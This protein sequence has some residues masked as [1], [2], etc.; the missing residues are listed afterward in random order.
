M[1]FG[2]V[3]RSL[4]TLPSAF[5]SNASCSGR[6]PQPQRR[7]ALFLATMLLPGALILSPLHAQKAYFA[8]AETALGGLFVDPEGVAVDRNGNVYVANG[9]DNEVT[10]MPAGCTSLICVTTLGGG[11]SAPVGVA[12]DASGNVYVADSGNNAVKEMPRGCA[13]SS[14]VTTLGGGFNAPRG[15]AVDGSG[16]VYVGDSGNNAVKEISPGCTSSSCVTTLGGGFN[17]PWGVAVDASGNVYVV[18]R[19]NNALKEMPPGC[20]SSGCVTALSLLDGIRH[21]LGVAVDGNGNIWVASGADSPQMFEIPAGC[22]SSSCMTPLYAHGMPNAVA[23]DASGNYYFNER[24][25]DLVI[26]IERHGVNFGAVAVGTAEP[27]QKTLTFAFTAADTGITASVLTQGAK[28]LDFADAGTGSCDT[29]G[30]SYTY[31]AG[32]ACTMDVTFAPKY[33]GARCGAVV[34]SDASG[35]IATA[36]I[37]GTG[38]GPQLVFQSN[39]TPI[40]VGAGAGDPSGLA[41]DAIGNVYVADPSG[42]GEVRE[43]PAGCTISTC[44]P[45]ELGGNNSEGQV[46]RQPTSVAVDGAGNLYVADSGNSAVKMMPP[47]CVAAGCVA[48]LTAFPYPGSLAVD[49]AGKLYASDGNAVKELPSGCASTSCVITLGGWFSDI[50][51]L[52]VDGSGNLYVLD[53]DAVKEMPPGCTSASCATT[54]GGGFIAPAAVALDGSGNIYVTDNDHAS[55]R[56]F[57]AV[58]EMP[59]GCASSS[60]VTPFGTGSINLFALKGVAVDGSGKVYVE[61]YYANSVYALNLATVP[62]LSF[63]NTT[64]GSQSSDSPQTVTLRNI[65][66]A[67]LI[68]PAPGVGENPYVSAG[69]T[70]DASTTCPE[71]TSSSSAGMLAAGAGCQLAVD[72]A[73]TTAGPITGTAVVTDNTLNV[74]YATQ[75]IGLSGAGLA[76]IITPTVTVIPTSS[77]INSAQAFTVTV[78]VSGGPGNPTPTGSVTLTSGAYTSAVTRLFI[79]SADI[80]VPAG[81][82]ALGNDILTLTYTPDSESAS[83]YTT[84]TGT[85]PVTVVQAIGSC[86]TANPNPNPNPASFAA[87]GDFN[88]DCKSDILWRNNSTEQVYIWLMNGTTYPGSGGPGPGT[89]S[90]GTPTSDWVIQGAGDFNG[91]GKAD[92]LWRNSTTGEV[93]IWL[94][95]G[96]T[97]AGSGSL[98][99]VS[100]DWSIKGIGDFNGDGKADILWRNSTTGQVYLWFINGT[101]MSGG[102]SVTYISSD[103]VIQGIGDFNGDGDADILWHNS[104]TGQVFIW[105]MNGTTLT[106]SGSLG[107]VSSDW[108]IAGVGDFNGDGKSDILWRNSTT[109]QVYLW[110]INGTAMSGGGSVSYVSSDWVIQGVGDYDG[111][112]R[113]GIL[114]RNTSSEQAYIWLMNGATITSQG[115]PGTPAA[116]WQIEP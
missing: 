102:G 66:N 71:V 79:A 99:Y 37:F 4:F 54:L 113:A 72:F 16:N 13:S 30:T 81:S 19:G 92:I 45:V 103:W 65:G 35:V 105:L 67:P 8:D 85:A 23:V 56:G 57:A 36:Y 83:T 7:L 42:L 29:V 10:E 50:G 33:A 14:C 111:S 1:G 69:F 18:D 74:T 25:E 78:T 100:S 51:A 101:T 2:S 28:G 21:P 62:S 32:Q 39:Q 84:A 47:G 107:Y 17:D 86:T 48:T 70:L 93:F 40:V 96:S 63:A 31:S 60:C 90:P 98:G 75:S 109:G 97:I 112:G 115:S 114:W 9:L 104:T 108:S 89:G 34:L 5:R 59:A 24:E 68:F 11:F 94:M 91:D 95:N 82:L 80:I 87:V 106:S 12:V 64:V 77:N 61:D 116:V 76:A 20:A 46:F 27:A 22:T 15:V 88:G 26:E 53:D 52:A 41:V 44:T 3:V 6:K 49:G 110:F 73:P 43:F 38:Q 58:L 55:G